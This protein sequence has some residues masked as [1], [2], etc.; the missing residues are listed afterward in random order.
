MLYIFDEPSVG[1][2]P[3][4]VARINSIFTKLRDKGNTVLIIEHDPDVIKIADWVIEVGPGA[5]VHG[6]EIMFEGSYEQLLQSDCLTGK[7][8]SKMTTI[9]KK[10]RHPVHFY[11]GE[12]SNA[13][14]LKNEHLDIPQ[15]LLTV[16]T[17]VAGSGK[18]TL[19]EHS[20]RSTYPEAIMVTQASLAANSRSNPATFIGIM[21]NIR[22]AFAKVN[23]VKPSLFS[24]NSEGACPACEGRGYIESNLAF[25]ETVKQTCEVCQG[26]RY[27]M[28]ALA[29]KYQGKDITEVLDLTIEEALDF[30]KSAPAIKKKIKAM[31]EV[32]LGYLTL[33][34]PTSTLSGGERQRLKLANEFYQ[35]GNL[36]ILD[37]PSTGLHLSDISRLMKIMKH[38]VDQGNTL[39]VIEHQLDIIRQADWI[40]D[41]GP[42]G[43]SAGGQVIYAGPPAGLRNCSASL[44]A[45]Y[46]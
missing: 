36:F 30:F 39:V 29:F 46:I 25:M 15:G 44:T 40:I 41:I 28:E 35:K 13:N 17:G 31:N 22:K 7:Y 34:Q 2:H 12:I 10:P 33:G 38:F 9:N 6:G 16:L 37:E 21:D 18:S 45:Q 26:K 24:Y 19:V 8:L 5:G 27:K 14:N 43:G 4:D 20:L 23:E 42:E 11:Q 1:L 3:R 32:G